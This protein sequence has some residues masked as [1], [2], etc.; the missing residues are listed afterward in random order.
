MT[1]EYYKSQ[2]S[3]FDKPHDFQIGIERK[4]AYTRFI[5]ENIDKSA[6]NDILLIGCGNSDEKELF[7]KHG[8]NVIGVDL[9]PSPGILKMDMH[10]L[11][12]KRNMF[13]LVSASHVLE[14]AYNIFLVLKQINKV[15]RPG[16]YLCLEIP[17]HYNVNNID[18]IDFMNWYYMYS[19]YI[20][21]VIHCKDI[22]GLNY[23]KGDFDNY[24][25][26]DCSKLI[27]R[28]L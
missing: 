9:F 27:V 15:L 10:K 13:D 18:R 12:F 26:T 25:S 2:A 23:Q 16:G 1:E 7:K 14:H 3:K 21:R 5:M 17:T 19:N 11:K 6:V 20:S 8:F 22:I 4:K 28:K 24:C